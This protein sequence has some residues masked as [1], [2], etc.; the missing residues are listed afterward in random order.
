MGRYTP[1]AIAL[2]WLIAIG[3]LINLA[4]GAW[5]HGAI[6][7]SESRDTA[8]AAFQWHKSLGLTVLV[9]SIVRLA[10]RF[11]HPPPPLPA[12]MPMWE[13]RLAALTHALFY[14]LMVGIPLSGWLYVST[15]WRGDGPFTI[16]TLWFGWFQVPHL[17][18]LHETGLALRE[19]LA[20]L[21]LNAH[22]WLAWA[23]LALALLHV[24]AALRHQFGLRDGILARMLPGRG[25]GARVEP[26]RAGTRGRLAALATVLLAVGFVLAAINS[27]PVTTSGSSPSASEALRSLVGSSELPRWQVDHADSALRFS[28]RHA[29][30]DFAGRFERW[31]AAIYFDPE[32]PAD[33]RIAAIIETGSAT[34]GVPMHDKTLP[35]R[36]WFHVARYPHASYRLSE[37]RALE[38]GGYAV[39]GVLSIK[40][41]EVEV[42]PLRL[43]LEGN[44]LRMAGEITLDRAEVDMGMESDPAGEYVSR[45]IGIQLKLSA[46]PQ[47]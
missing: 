40:E 35:E 43:W 26:R 14:L 37:I 25:A 44:T 15:Q 32:R 6:D 4:L 5:M 7:Q 36:E 34:D 42:G 41:H 19:Q 22:A 13:R 29:G 20:G 12:A 11:L 30:R 47:P 18:G 27:A 2:H 10:W 17:F 39:T 28:G 16:P 9:L 23:M 46:R 31:R 3:L 33:T 8:I 1:V 38:E 45:D 21:A 24:A